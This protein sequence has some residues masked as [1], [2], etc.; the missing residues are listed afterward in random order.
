MVSTLIRR[1]P[2]VV[3]SPCVVDGSTPK[4]LPGL[5]PFRS[6]TLQ[7]RFFVLTFFHEFA[8][9]PPGTSN[10]SACTRSVHQADA[11]A[12]DRCWA[13]GSWASSW[14]SGSWAYARRGCRA[15][16]DVLFAIGGDDVVHMPFMKDVVHDV[17]TRR[18]DSAFL[19]AARPCKVPMQSLP[20]RFGRRRLSWKAWRTQRCH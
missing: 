18:T 20:C 13:S 12:S 5:I 4:L 14:A 19:Q 11:R 3:P 2:G 10:A 15:H 9:R 7:A 17:G 8:A 6:D 16:M 1:A